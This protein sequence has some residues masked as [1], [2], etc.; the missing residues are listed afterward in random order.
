MV[1]FSIYLNRHVF[2]MA[3]LERKALLQTAKTL[4]RLHIF[5]VIKLSNY[6]CKISYRIGKNNADAD[7]L[8]RKQEHTTTIFPE[9]LKAISNTMM[10]DTV[11][12]AET[13]MHPDGKV[14]TDEEI[15]SELLEG[16]ALSAYDWRKAQ[17]SDPNIN[18]IMD[19]VLTG[20]MPTTTQAEENR[21]DHGYLANW[22]K[23]KLKDG[24]LYRTCVASIHERNNFRA[25]HDDL[26]HQGRDRT[27]SLIKERF[28]W[29]GMNSYIGNHVTL[30]GRCIRRKTAPLKAAE[31]V[32]LSS[33][34][35]VELVCT[36][37]LTLERSK[38]GYENILV[39]TDH[40]SHFAQAIPTRNQ[41]DHTTYGSPLKTTLC[42]TVFLPNFILTKGLISSLRPSRNHVK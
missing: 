12:L 24:V 40:F 19:Y 23:F 6:N 39:I 5:T 18:C 37:Y 28:Y 30:C 22:E 26:G 9:V 20:Q 14:E 21:I 16:T 2:V 41:T 29:P 13:T 36:D 17:A 38:R 1:K 42:T 25:H 31:L 27:M 7:G 33:T 10:E 4:V 35:P 15:P 3:Q 34:A 11:P 32:N 8:S